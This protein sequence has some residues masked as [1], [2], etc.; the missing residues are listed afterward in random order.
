MAIF[1]YTARTEE[2]KPTTGTIQ[3]EDVSELRKILRL[4]DLYLT[5]TRGGAKQKSHRAPEPSLFDKKVKP[6]DMVVMSRQLATMVRAGMPIHEILEGLREGTDKPAL[7]YALDDIVVSVTSGQPLSEGMRRHPKLFS[8]LYCTLVEAGEVAGTLEHTL[9]IA[10]EQLDRDA[11]LREQVRGALIYPK[12]VVGACLGTVG[13]MLTLVVPTFKTVYSSFQAELPAATKVL[14]ATSE[15][16]VG[17]WWMVIL[18]T[19]ALVLGF[20]KFRSTVY[21]SRLLDRTSLRLPIFGPLF[22]KIAI[23]RFA[24]TLG[25]AVKGGVPV[26]QALQISGN[27]AGNTVVTDAIHEVALR[28][29][30]GSAIAPQLEA[31]GQFPPMVVRM[32]AA[33]ESSGN[34]DE[35]L[36]EINKFYERDVRYAVE[37][38]MKVIEPMMTVL[39]GAIVLLILLAL[40]MPIFG[41][42]SAMRGGG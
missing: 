2:G 17:Y 34:L 1:K 33:G 37:R 41:L 21:G 11:T 3:A 10:A 25:G 42:G 22:R 7:A 18:G 26:L 23:A 15:V 36:D 27:T 20:R 28:V 19:I 24:Q 5:R 31:S 30:E 38:M 14:M 35:M 40:Y 29:R 16:V 32:V 12:L 8:R 9:E 4:N 6:Q 39:V 13:A